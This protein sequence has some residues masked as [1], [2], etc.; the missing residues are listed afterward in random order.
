MTDKPFRVEHAC[1]S[2]AAQIPGHIH[3]DTWELAYI[4]HGSGMRTLGDDVSEFSSGDIVLTPPHVQHC[5]TFSANDT[6]ADG[7]IENLVVFIKDNWLNRLVLNEPVIGRALHSIIECRESVVLGGRSGK[8]VAALVRKAEAEDEAHQALRI[9]ESL[10]EFSASVESRRIPHRQTP[11]RDERL[12]DAFRIFVECNY[13]RRITLS[14]AAGESGLSR[15]LFCATFK[16]LMGN[17]FVECLNSVRVREACK[18]LRYTGKSVT[19]I[20]AATA[21]DDVCYFNRVFK[22]ITGVSPREWRRQGKEPPNAPMPVPPFE[23]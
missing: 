23:T 3:D 10:V 13:M 6:K 12:R 18:M 8:R 16:K 20:S 5:W 9:I 14:D 17:T 2:P 21:F 1:L 19:E 11:T 4:I 15:S 7:K 22:R